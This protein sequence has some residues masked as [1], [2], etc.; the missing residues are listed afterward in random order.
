[1]FFNVIISVDGRDDST[2]FVAL[3]DKIQMQCG[4]WS[5]ERLNAVLAETNR[6]I[7]KAWAYMA[8]REAKPNEA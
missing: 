8:D 1:M 2:I 5:E 3:E 6:K 7:K 4:D